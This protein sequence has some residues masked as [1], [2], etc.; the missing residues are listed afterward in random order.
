[1]TVFAFVVKRL[2]FLKSI[3]LMAIYF[4]SLIKVWMVFSNPKLLRWIDDVEDFVLSLPNTDVSLHKYGGS[5]F[6]YCEKEFAHLHSNGILDILLNQKIKR[7]LLAE[8]KVDEHHLF[9]NSGLMLSC[10]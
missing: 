9:K 6:N 3:P 1:M 7:N 4:D 8:G 2:G 5:Q 10:R